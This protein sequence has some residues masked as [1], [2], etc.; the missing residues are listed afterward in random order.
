MI[1]ALQSST[2]I[3]NTHEYINNICNSNYQQNLLAR[4]Q[5]CF[6]NCLIC[7]FLHYISREEWACLS[8]TC[9]LTFHYCTGVWFSNLC[10]IV[11][12]WNFQK[13]YYL[14]AASTKLT[15]TKYKMGVAHPQLPLP[16]GPTHFIALCLAISSFHN[17]DC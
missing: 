12:A 3:I 8:I 6:C 15:C 10:N 1:T 9:S 5:Q 2:Q 14:H 7:T 17:H 4:S 11:Q 13:P 16:F